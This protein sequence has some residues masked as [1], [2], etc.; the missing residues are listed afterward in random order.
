MRG[1]GRAESGDFANIY[2]G[3]VIARSR[4]NLIYQT[5]EGSPAGEAGLV[6]RM[7]CYALPSQGDCY[8]LRAVEIA[9]R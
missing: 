5:T 9:S 6:H 7:L 3:E 4:E 1:E 2:S 8:R